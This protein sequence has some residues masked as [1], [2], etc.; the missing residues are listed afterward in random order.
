MTPTTATKVRAHD[1]TSRF[2]RGR[3]RPRRRRRRGSPNPRTAT[4]CDDDTAAYGPG[5]DR[6]GGLGRQTRPDRG[7]PFR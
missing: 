1:A 2:A 5:I 6:A 3:R 7:M 4:R